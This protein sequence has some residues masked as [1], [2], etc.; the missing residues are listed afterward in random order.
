MKTIKTT[1][2]LERGLHVRLK[3]AASRLGVNAR[4]LVTEGL[5]LVLARYEASGDHD[6]LRARAQMARERLRA[7]Y[8]DGPSDLSQTYE[9]RML[10][11]AEPEVPYEP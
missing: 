11:A 2:E 10:K 6:E 7:G 8:F 9:T 3:T 4:D 5:E 1:F